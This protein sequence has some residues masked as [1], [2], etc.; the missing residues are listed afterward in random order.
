MDLRGAAPGIA[1]L[2]RRLLQAL[3]HRGPQTWLL[4]PL[5]CQLPSECDEA[6]LSKAVHTMHGV[7]QCRKR[8]LQGA[9]LVFGA[10]PEPC[11]Q[12]Y[13]QHNA[14]A[15]EPEQQGHST[16]HCAVH[17]AHAQKS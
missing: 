2:L 6:C 9:W 12:H 11:P 3:Q 1:A 7:L 8:V 15:D 13:I 5:L 17:H 14:P 10:V 16:A 4:L